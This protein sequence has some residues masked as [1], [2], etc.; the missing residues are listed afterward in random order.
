MRFW[1]SESERKVKEEALIG[2]ASRTHVEVLHRIFSVSKQFRGSRL[3]FY[4]LWDFM[5]RVF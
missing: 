2:N 3:I 1:I 5:W 4:N